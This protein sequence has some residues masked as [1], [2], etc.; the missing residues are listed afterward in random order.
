M[1]KRTLISKLKPTDT[2]NIRGF[3]DT[4]RLQ[5]SIQFIVIRDESGKVQ[6]TVYRPELP[7]IAAVFDTLTPE[8]TVSVTGKCV[9]AP[10]VKLGGIEIIPTGVEILSAAKLLP[11]DKDSGIELQMDYRWLDLRDR[12]KTAYF[13]LMTGIT[14]IMR[15]WFVN[16]GFI[17]GMTPKLTAFS[18]EG[19]AEVFRVKYFDSMAYL[20]QSPQLFKQM[21]MAAGWGK[22]F[23]FGAC[24]RAEKSFTSRHATEFFALDAELAFI[25]DENDIMDAEEAMLLWTLKETKA[26]YGKLFADELGIEFTAQTAAFPRVSLLDAYKLL[27]TE[28]GYKVPK[29]SK[30][31]LD[32]DGERLL[33]EIA[34]E[35]FGSDFIWITKF[36]S[37]ARAFYTKRYKDD[38]KISHGFD[39]LYKGVEI[40]SGAVREENPD[41]LKENM[42]SKG[43]NPDDMQFYIQFFEYGIPPHGGFAMGLARLY[44][45][46][47]GAPSVKDTTF[48]FRGPTRLAP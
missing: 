13:K 23:E 17:E 28:K 33:C 10:N 8:S 45:K 18:T 16:N 27:E 11:L 4:L 14:Q 48:L 5:K 6:V 42:K 26:R 29:A 35:K 7:K 15:E 22:F 43:I 19:G 21:A 30:G 44:A 25:D 12:K 20:T 9:S 32:P 47:F 34:K 38:P 39:L 31:D 41:L 2:V 37:A 40:T 1:L 24:Y 36:P 46:M 3:V